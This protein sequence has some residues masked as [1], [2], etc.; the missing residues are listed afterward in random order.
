MHGVQHHMQVRPK[1]AP[2]PGQQGPCALGLPAEGVQDGQ[3][4]QGGWGGGSWPRLLL[5]GCP[6]GWGSGQAGLGGCRGDFEADARQGQPGEGGQ[7]FG[8][9]GGLACIL[10]P[11]TAVRPVSQMHIIHAMYDYVYK[12]IDPNGRRCI[13][14]KVLPWRLIVPPGMSGGQRGRADE[15]PREAGAEILAGCVGLS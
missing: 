14:C 1:S 15:G 13:L 3:H 6:G 4:A 11:R 5:R 7:D 10:L 9:A 12:C 2:Q 8:G